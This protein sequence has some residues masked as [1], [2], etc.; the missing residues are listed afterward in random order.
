VVRDADGDFWALPAAEN[1]WDH[2]RPFV[3]DDD[4]ELEPVPK[5]YKYMLGLP[6]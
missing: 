4:S 1:P 2:R 3:P 6:H 5:H